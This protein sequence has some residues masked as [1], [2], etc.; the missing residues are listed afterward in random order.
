MEPDRL[1]SFTWHPYAVDPA[2]DYSI[3]EPTLVEFTLEKAAVGTLLN[4]IESGFDKIPA[5][6]RSEAF[7]MNEGGWEQQMIN[8]RNYVANS[9]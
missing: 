2:M 7:A 5:N 6:R 4:L 9:S 1:F 8:I 3:E